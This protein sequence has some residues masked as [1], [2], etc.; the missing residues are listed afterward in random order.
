MYLINLFKKWRF[1]KKA[2]KIDFQHKK[3]SKENMKLI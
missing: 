2:I 3:L 1:K